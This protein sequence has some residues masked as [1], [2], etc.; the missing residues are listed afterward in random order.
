MPYV[1]IAENATWNSDPVR[2]LNNL[3]QVHRD[4]RGNLTR[5][6]SWF[7]QQEGPD[8]RRV[9]SATARR[10]PFEHSDD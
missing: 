8:N 7:M 6:F 10:E 3:L 9:H 5:H 2:D 4:A 1:S